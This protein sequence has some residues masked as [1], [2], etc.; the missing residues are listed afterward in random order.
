MSVPPATVGWGLIGCGDIAAKQSTLESGNS[1]V[2]LT[3]TLGRIC[4][5]QNSF[6]ANRVL[7]EADGGGEEEVLGPDPSDRSL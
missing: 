3:S 1:N 5:V 6:L 4:A 7:L 2:S